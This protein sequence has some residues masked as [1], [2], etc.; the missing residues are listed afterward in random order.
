MLGGHSY[1]LAK[2]ALNL[3]NCRADMNNP[4]VA[5]FTLAFDRIA[6]VHRVV[7]GY[8]AATAAR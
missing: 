7:T 3:R 4:D 5:A 1:W 2:S 8:V 6:V